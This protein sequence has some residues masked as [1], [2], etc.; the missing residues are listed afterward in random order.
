MSRDGGCHMSGEPRRRQNG[1]PDKTVQFG[2]PDA[3]HALTDDCT[4]VGM[5]HSPTVTATARK[6]YASYYAATAKRDSQRKYLSSL[7]NPSGY[8]TAIERDYP[9]DTDAECGCIVLCRPSRL[10]KVRSPLHMPV[11]D[12][13]QFQSVTRLCGTSC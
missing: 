10:R 4:C 3:Q 8:V 5:Q 6:N 9:I 1:S 12:D 11:V 7:L 13:L 2:S